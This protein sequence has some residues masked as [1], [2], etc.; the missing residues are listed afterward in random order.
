MSAVPLLD[1]LQGAG[2]KLS[3]DGRD[4]EVRAPKGT[5]TPELK[6]R[7]RALKP[8][9]IAELRKGQSGSA[10]TTS[11]QPQVEAAVASNDAAIEDAVATQISEW[12]QAIEAAPRW[13]ADAMDRLHERQAELIAFALDFLN[14]PLAIEA[15][16]A[17][18]TAHEL[19]AVSH[20]FPRIHR[21]CWGIIPHMAWERGSSLKAFTS[22]SV[23][24]R[25]P[26]GGEWR[27]YRTCMGNP[28]QYGRPFWL[29]A[30]TDLK[31]R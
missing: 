21:H 4:I 17:G 24:W 16:R 27:T 29:V 30:G 11:E 7:I 26:A 3:T 25:S 15:G 6:E 23:L 13:P 5:L 20:E 19:F 2:A 8:Q 22:A 14:S 18:W 12:K 9:I 1:E 28:R 31:G 10:A